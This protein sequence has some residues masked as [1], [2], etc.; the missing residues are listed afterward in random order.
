MLRKQHIHPEELMLPDLLSKV[1]L[2]GG[3]LLILALL[4][5]LLQAVAVFEA[6]S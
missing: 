1:V 6:I 3:F 4:L 2:V 5:E